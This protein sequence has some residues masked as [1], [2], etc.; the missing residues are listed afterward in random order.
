MC[1]DQFSGKFLWQSVHRKLESGQVNDWPKEGVASS[2]AVEG[3]RVYYVSNRAEVVCLDSNGFADGNQGYQNEHYQTD[4]DADV[5]WS[6]DMIKELKVFPHNLACCSPLIV[7]DLVFVVTGNGVDENHI[8]V[9]APEAPSFIALNRHTGKLAWKDNS[10]GKNVLHGQWGIP[11]YAAEPVPQ[12]IFPGGDGWLRAFDPPTGKLLWKFNCNKST[13]KYDLGGTGDKSDFVNTAPVVHKG[14]VYI[15]TGQDPEHFTG[16]AYF[17]CLDLAKAVK[18]GAMTKSRDVSPANDNFDPTAEA[19]ETS[20]LAWV[21]GG[22]DKRPTSR[23]DYLFGRTMSTACIV[24][25]VLYAAELTGYVHCLDARTGKRY[26][27]Y[28]T[29][30][31]IWNAPFYADGK[32]FLATE[33]GDLFIFKHFEKPTEETDVDYVR[34]MAP[35]KVEGIKQSKLVA[36]Q[37]EAKYLIRQIEFDAPIRTAPTVVDGVL[38]IVT[39]KNMYAI[40]EKR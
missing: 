38:Y 5:L 18:F 25:D 20:A 24:G 36:K 27:T 3:N 21:Y 9:P 11:S 35:N 13:A 8:K 26:W 14:R 2:P 6:F 7:G 23:R 12:V 28:D 17:W 1:F 34:A 16:T 30:G 29:K 19:N 32:V 39:E 33:N 10:P 37:F 40:A 31:S 15:G 22:E 4:T